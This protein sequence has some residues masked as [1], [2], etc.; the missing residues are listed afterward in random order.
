MKQYN[1]IELYGFQ[2]ANF[3]LVKEGFNLDIDNDEMLNIEWDNEPIEHHEF[4]NAEKIIKFCQK[5]NVQ[6][7]KTYWG[8]IY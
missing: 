8:K 5:N 1:L 2:E 7:N 4:F 6:I 3:I